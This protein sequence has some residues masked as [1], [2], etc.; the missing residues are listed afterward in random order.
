MIAIGIIG[1]VF[2]LGNVFW[3]NKYANN[4]S[5]VQAYEEA[6]ENGYQED[7]KEWAKG[8]IGE[9]VS[10]K[11]GNWWIAD[12]DTGV[13]AEESIPEEQNIKVVD[14]YTDKEKK[15]WIKL[16][17]REKIEIGH[18]DAKIDFSSIE[19]TVTFKDFDQ[20]VLKEEKVKLGEKAKAPTVPEREG[21]R[22]EKW[23][24]DF[25]N[26]TENLVVTAQYIIDNST[27]IVVKNVSVSPGE[28][29][30]EIPI[31]VKNNPGILGMTLSVFYDEEVMKLTGAKN[32]EAFNDV[33]TFTKGKKL[34]NECRFV[35]DGQDISEDDVHDGEILVLTFDILKKAN[36]GSYQISFTCNN[37]IINQKLEPIFVSIVNGNVKIS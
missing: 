3:N 16:S 32:G 24:K 23:D 5:E 30:V 2:L 36:K 26:V 1:L 20:S 13:K 17:N 27:K 18:V 34:K 19:Y 7:I 25:E 4:K 10:I 12:N 8:L 21:Y 33:L 22:F 11:K 15:L 28:K 9:N 35:W 37:D 29:K 31:S 6:K 14:C